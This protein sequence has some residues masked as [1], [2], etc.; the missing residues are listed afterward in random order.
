M[1]LRHWSSEPQTLRLCK[2]SLNLSQC[3]SA[4]PVCYSRQER[5]R[6]SNVYIDRWCVVVVILSLSLKRKSKRAIFF[7]VLIH[8]NEK[9]YHITVTEEFHVAEKNG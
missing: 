7:T 1:K 6:K 9:N 5:T 3:L 8:I 2:L 4:S